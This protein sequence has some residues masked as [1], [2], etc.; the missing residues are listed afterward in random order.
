MH[1]PS[2]LAFCLLGVLAL[3]CGS[4]PATKTVAPPP[5]AK[6]PAPAPEAAKVPPA[7]EGPGHVDAELV[8]AAA[9]AKGVDRVKI[10]VEPG[11]AV[12]YLSVYHQDEAAIPE[13][14]RKQL[15]AQYPGAK[16]TRYES[17]F[18]ADKGR[19]YEIEVETADK[20]E[21]EFSARADGS[22]V[23][24]ECHI[25]AAALPGPVRAA[26]EKAHPNVALK[27]VEKKT[28]TG[29]GD[30]YEL[31]FE[32]DGRVHGRRRRDSPRARDPGGHRGPRALASA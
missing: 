2:A 7:P 8:R 25:D 20:Q 22:V 31:E 21:C 3:A 29:G 9:A 24:T 14:V 30:E 26:F 12:R 15:D 13:P 6:I 10:E 18:V 28:V 16:I 1:H 19:L 4:E 5:P 17:E 11:G 27:E 23:Y 32:L